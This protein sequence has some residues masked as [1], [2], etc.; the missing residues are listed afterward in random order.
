MIHSL[1]LK[2]KNKTLEINYIYDSYYK[3]LMRN[4]SSEIEFEAE[5]YM[6]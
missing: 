5:A 6:V 1:F 3:L 4:Y 2:T